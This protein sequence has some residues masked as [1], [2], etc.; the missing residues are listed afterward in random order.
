M[1]KS[2]R[3]EEPPL[4]MASLGRLA[5]P[6]ANG[7][8]PKRQAGAGW[9]LTSHALPPPLRLL[10]ATCHHDSEHPASHSVLTGALG[11][12]GAPRPRGRV[13]ELGLWQAWLQSH[14]L[15]AV[16]APR[17]STCYLNTTQGPHPDHPCAWWTPFCQFSLQ[18][19]CRLRS[20][21]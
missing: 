19:V 12:P 13:L 10:G 21:W 2:E 11:G 7:R 6:E 3:A 16:S 8:N 4:E 9:L 18:P 5:G 1:G 17:T 15:S 14:C 20:Y